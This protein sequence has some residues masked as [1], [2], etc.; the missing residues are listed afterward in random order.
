MPR[1]AWILLSCVCIGLGAVIAILVYK[2]IEE[3]PEKVLIQTFL[4]SS[5][6]VVE[7]FGAPLSVTYT[8]EGAAV[9]FHADKVRGKYRFAISGSKISGVVRVHWI[10]DVNH[11]C[12]VES[13]DL[14]N[15]P[16]VPERIWEISCKEGA[17]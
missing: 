7:R 9:E 2:L 10:T 4:L 6:E 12:R 16:E 3:R 8:P 11:A 15:S 13:I 1:K 5:P 14:L 17:S